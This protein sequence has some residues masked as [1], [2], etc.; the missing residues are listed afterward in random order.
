[1]TMLVT[2]QE[3]KDHLRIDMPDEDQDLTLKVHA[4]SGA[5]LRYLKSSAAAYF[6][7]QGEV[8]EGALPFEVKAATLLMTGYLY[9]QRDED[10]DREFEQGYLP[11]PVTALLFPLRDPALA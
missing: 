6:D 7:E 4:A 3:A 2:L 5:V 10:T 11:R 8:I 1:M 9:R